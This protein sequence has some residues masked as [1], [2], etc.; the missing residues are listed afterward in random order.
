MK[1]LV[2]DDDPAQLL[3]S[4]IAL[5]DLGVFDVVVANCGAEVMELARQHSPDVIL[6]DIILQDIDGPE[7]FAGLRGDR[8]TDKIPVIFHTARVDPSERSELLALGAAGFIEKPFNPAQLAH[9]VLRILES[10]SYK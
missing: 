3:L 7:V 2:V 4:S 1:I 5:G 6:L 8:A 10:Q 9:E